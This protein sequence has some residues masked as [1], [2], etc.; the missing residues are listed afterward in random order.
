[1]MSP[2]VCSR[3]RRES[4][5]TVVVTGLVREGPCGVRDYG[6][7]LAGE[8]V[9]RGMA[10]EVQALPAGGRGL[11]SCL[12]AAWRLLCHA[13]SVPDGAVV[14]WSYSAFAYGW[15]GVPLPGVAFGLALRLRGRRVVT[16]L[17]E[18]ATPWQ[19]GIKRWL[20]AASQ[21]LA[22]PLVVLGS[23][24]VVATTYRR[25]AW[26][27]PL[28]TVLRRRVH[29]VPVFSNIP[30]LEGAPGISGDGEGGGGGGDVVVLCHRWKEARGE[31]LLE[32]VRILNRSAP[33]RVVLLG[34]PEPS[35]PSGREW[36]AAAAAWGVVD[37]VKQTGPV[38]AEEFSRRLQNCA[39]VV[40]VN[41]DGPNTRRS[42]LASAVAHGCAV[43]ALDGPERWDRLTGEGAVW[44][45]PP[46]G[47][48][49]AAAVEELLSRPE[50]RRALGLRAAAF[51]QRHLSLGLAGDAFARLLH[52]GADGGRPA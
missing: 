5:G 2:P 6:D 46:D 48:A 51:Y 4:V 8:L 28:A 15:R 18:A 11:G 29:V 45:V 30:V 40:L 21:R 41:A 50:A 23:S 47:A 26:L 31:V 35:S 13:G 10:V 9:R 49:L 12:G 24:V 39:V 14:V 7:L 34:A 19:P 16:V 36:Q 17:H 20:I 37:H 1:M 33:V 22:L 38:S 3:G 25:A 43:V 27:S 52:T 32:A 44:V 42:T